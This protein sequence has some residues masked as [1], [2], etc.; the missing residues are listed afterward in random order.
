MR[1]KK[2]VYLDP[3]ELK[4]DISG[5]KNVVWTNGC[6]DLLHVGHLHSLKE[7][8]QYG[9]ILIVG[10]NSDESVKQLKGEGRPIYTEQDRANLL[11]SLGF[12]DAV[13]MFNGLNPMEELKIIK[14]D[15]FA[16]GAEYDLSQL[17]EAQLVSNYGG[18][19]VSLSLIDSISTS[20]I[21]NRIKSL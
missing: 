15:I 2:Q 17:P 5:E 8:A 7:A 1:F 4:Q 20:D 13:L 3:Q 9:D 10:L 21:I 12:V 19:V 6:F 18:K 11:S 16:K 14:P